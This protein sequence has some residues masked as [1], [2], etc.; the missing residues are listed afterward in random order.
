MLR[1]TTTMDNN[2]NDQAQMVAAPLV[3]EIGVAPIVE[4]IGVATLVEGI[5][6]HPVENSS[7]DFVP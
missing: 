4:G 3:G 1:Q 6:F 2:G 7:P 5:Q